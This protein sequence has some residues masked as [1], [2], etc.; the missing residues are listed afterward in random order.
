MPTPPPRS[1]GKEGRSVFPVQIIASLQE[2]DEFEKEKMKKSRPVV[3]SRL[4]RLHKWLDDYVP[5]TIKKAVTNFF[6]G[7][8]N[9][10]MSLYDGVKKILKDIVEKETEEEQQQEE[11]NDLTPHEHERALK[12][13]YRSFVIPGLPKTDID[14]YFDQTKPHIK[15]LIENQLKEM[16]STKIIMTLWVIWKKPIKLLIKLPEHAKNAQ[17]LDD[18]TAD[19][20]YFEKIEMPFNSLMTEFFDAND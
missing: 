19:D 4:S 15:T 14:S 2:M 16:G 11:D 17:E 10:M 12:G 9:S 18:G 7:M 13:A 5:K 1:N 3:E 6:L 20:I 8:K